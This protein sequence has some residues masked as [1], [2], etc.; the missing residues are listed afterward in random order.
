[1]PLLSSEKSQIKNKLLSMKFLDLA[2]NRYSSRKYQNT[3]IEKEKL[4]LILES[5]RI[6]P[7]AA[8]RQP[9]HFIVVEDKETLSR[10]YTTYEREWLHTAPMIIVCCGDHD[11][12]WKRSYDQKDHTDVDVSIAIDH[13][14]LQA[15]ELGLATCWICHFDAEKTGNYLTYLKILNLLPFCRSVIR[16]IQL[17][18]TGMIKKEN[19]LSKLF[20][21]RNGKF[22][23]YYINLTIQHSILTVCYLSYS[24]FLDMN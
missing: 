20:T 7:S 2:K 3:V 12:V 16:L 9:W 11:E 6:A 18:L 10:L 17:I 5:A 21:M 14:T 1:M 13:M 19:Y 4:D 23:V 8:N 24:F 15:T 22:T